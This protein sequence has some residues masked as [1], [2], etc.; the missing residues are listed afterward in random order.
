MHSTPDS[1]GTGG[2]PEQSG[3]FKTVD[4]G[5]YWIGAG[6][7]SDDDQAMLVGKRIKVRWS[8]QEFTG[9]VTQYNEETG[10]HTVV[11]DT[12]DTKTSNLSSKIWSLLPTE[13]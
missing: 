3:I 5:G 12:G 10:S 4:Y 8:E 1:S 9:T 2:V 6:Y 7:D 13:L 11:Y